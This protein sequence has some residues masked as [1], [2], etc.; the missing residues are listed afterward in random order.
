MIR[1]PRTARKNLPKRSIIAQAIAGPVS[2]VAILRYILVGRVSVFI[3]VAPTS[4][5][6][7]PNSPRA[8]DHASTPA[9]IMEFF[10]NGSV[11]SMNVFKFPSP[12]LPAMISYRGSYAASRLHAAKIVMNICL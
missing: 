8:L 4:I 10:A 2:P 5:S 7:V 6:V 1:S 9:P 11:I 12:R 3:L